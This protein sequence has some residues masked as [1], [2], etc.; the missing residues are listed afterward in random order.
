MKT[1]AVA[2]AGALAFVPAAEAKKFRIS[3]TVEPAHVWAKRPARVIVRT[4]IVL[5]AAHELPFNVVGPW[6][7]RHGNA[8]FEPRLR[9]TGPKT[10]TARVRFPYGGRWRLIVP[11]WIPTGSASPPPV[12]HALRVQP[13]P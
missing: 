8:F 3:L 12:D 2:A 1:F 4:S 7:P 9:R 6:H 10:F 5:P 11:N 13:G